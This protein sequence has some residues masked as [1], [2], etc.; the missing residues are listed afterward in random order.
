MLR[1]NRKSVSI[2]GEPHDSLIAQ[3]C[4]NFR[5]ATMRHRKP[6]L[7]IKQLLAMRLIVVV[8]PFEDGIASAKKL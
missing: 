7:L 2:R 8:P 3:R 5:K 1:R 4:Q 6:M